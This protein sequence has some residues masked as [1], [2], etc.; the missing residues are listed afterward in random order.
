M[1][2]YIYLFA[3]MQICRPLSDSTVFT[4]FHMNLFLI[5]I[6][7]FFFLV[8]FFRIYTHTHTHIYIYVVILFT[9]SDFIYIYISIYIYKY[10]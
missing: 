8:E 5:N 6:Y 1:Y 9:L 10:I 3:C 4:V 7:H 2:I